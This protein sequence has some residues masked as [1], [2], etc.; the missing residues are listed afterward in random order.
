[1]IEL[2]AFVCL[3]ADPTQCKDVTL[4]L[5]GSMTPIQCL[6]QSQG[7]AI[8]WLHTKDGEGWRVARLTCGRPSKL[9]R[10]S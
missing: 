8:K 9:A 3:L 7:E 5:S 6:M 4:N 1:M 2:V 10:A